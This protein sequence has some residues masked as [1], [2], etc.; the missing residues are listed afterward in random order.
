MGQKLTFWL[1]VVFVAI[2]GIYVFKAAA[3][4]SGSTGLQTFAEAI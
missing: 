4:K 3:A 1:M 2:G